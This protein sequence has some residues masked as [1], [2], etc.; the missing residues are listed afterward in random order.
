MTRAFDMTA[1]QFLEGFLPRW[2]ASLPTRLAPFAERFLR[3]NRGV[4]EVLTQRA[5]AA[6]RAR[7]GE[8]PDTILEFAAYDPI[9]AREHRL[10]AQPDAAVLRRLREHIEGRI[11][12][13]DEPERTVLAMLGDDYVNARTE[14]ILL[15]QGGWDAVPLLLRKP[16]LA[17]VL[18]GAVVAVRDTKGRLATHPLKPGELNHLRTDVAK[19]EIRAAYLRDAVDIEDRTTDGLQRFAQALWSLAREPAPPWV[20]TPRPRT[21]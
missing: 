6:L 18:E 1:A 13:G 2:R 8:L 4:L 21:P 10:D 17:V 20:A 12:R 14:V 7:R 9:V 19:A 11:A 3:L 5:L 16:A 15:R